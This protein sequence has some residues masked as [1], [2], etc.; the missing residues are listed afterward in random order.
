VL[1]QTGFRMVDT[2]GAVRTSTAA[3]VQTGA[4]STNSVIR[5]TFPAPA[6]TATGVR[7]VVLE[8]VVANSASAL[9]TT[10]QEANDVAGTSGNSDAPDLVSVTVNAANNTATFTFDENVETLSSGSRTGF[11]LYYRLGGGSSADVPSLSADRSATDTR[12]VIA[13]FAGGTI[14]ELVAGGYVDDSAVFRDQPST[15]AV[16]TANPNRVDEE[17]LGS[18]FAAGGYIG[19]QLVSASRTNTTNVFGTVTG[20]AIKFVW[21]QAVSVNN[22]AGFFVIGPDGTRTNLTSC[23]L[24]ST[25]TTNTTVSC[26]LGTTGAEATAASTSVVATVAADAVRSTKTRTTGQGA[27]TVGNHEERSSF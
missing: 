12:S 27:I 11:H 10:P 4:T 7:G 3:T 14:N 25:V 21:D 18:T 13:Q 16:T 2:D 20:S 8:G 15:D 17:G 5:V 1:S 23:S 6:G 26:T 9:A 22:A 19:P 24:D